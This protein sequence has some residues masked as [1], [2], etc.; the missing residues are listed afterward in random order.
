MNNENEKEL[1]NCWD[2]KWAHPELVADGYWTIDGDTDASDQLKMTAEELEAAREGF[3][4]P[5][6]T[7]LEDKEN[8]DYAN[9]E[10]K[11]Y[12]TEHG[13][14]E[15]DDAPPVHILVGMPVNRDPK[16]KLPAF[17]AIA[18]GGLT[19]GGT[20]ELGALSQ[21][22][23]LVKSGVEMI[24]V[25][26]EYRTAPAHRYPAA[27]NDAHAAYQWLIE[28]AEEL[29]VDTDRIIISGVSTGGHL[30]L[31]LAF[32][33]KRYNWCG[34]PMPRGIIVLQPV[35]DDITDTESY[36]FSFKHPV[37]D[38][39]GIWDH[40]YVHIAFSLWL[41]ERF[42]D[43]TLPP[44][45]VINRATIEDVRGLPPVWIPVAGEFE[46]SRDSV[47]RFVNLLHQAHVFCDLHMW[48][49]TSHGNGGFVKSEFSK[50]VLNVCAGALKDA[51]NY[52][53]R[54]PWLN[55]E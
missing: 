2:P 50:R 6:R 16:K 3:R 39:S 18:G 31:A 38:K 42:G 34:A 40:E 44:E 25:T 10:W 15:E 43:P 51:I 19:G 17:F 14:P 26:F 53:F 27:V 21:R 1:F 4:A 36:H 23:M 8:P 48:G 20:A 28:H 30:S 37:T 55:E 24:S 12:Y 41:G 5:L 9:V 13:C 47:Y 49:G 54:R 7:I 45:A 33:L 11:D 29:G 52:D 22:S 46:P 35:M 32:R